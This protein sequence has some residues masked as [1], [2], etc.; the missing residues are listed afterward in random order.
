MSGMIRQGDILFVPVSERPEGTPVARDTDGR[1][2]VAR[3]EVTGHNHAIAEPEVVMIEATDGRRY[4]ISDRPYAVT[5]EEHAPAVLKNHV[6]EVRQ[7]RQYVR[8]EVRRVL[9]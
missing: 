4:L 8:G 5:H 6:Y 9:D 3:G 7:Q 2:I 1:L